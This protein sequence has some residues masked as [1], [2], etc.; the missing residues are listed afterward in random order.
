LTEKVAK[1]WL[2]L[3]AQGSVDLWL[4]EKTPDYHPYP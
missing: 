4:D 2:W 1:V 3:K